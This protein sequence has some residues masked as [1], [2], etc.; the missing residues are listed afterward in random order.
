M[1]EQARKWG[2]DKELLVN[3]IRE[4]E[5]GLTSVIQVSLSF[6][7]VSSQCHVLRIGSLLNWGIAVLKS[8]LHSLLQLHESPVSRFAAFRIECLCPN[9]SGRIPQGTGPMWSFL[10][11]LWVTC[12]SCERWPDLL[13]LASVIPYIFIDNCIP[14]H[15]LMEI[16]FV[17]REVLTTEALI[18]S[19]SNSTASD[20]TVLIWPG[21]NA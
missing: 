17:L 12:S 18:A 15:P 8:F 5:F 4:F 9:C 13:T 19:F 20:V 16:C 10:F 6:Y 14:L 21:F 2:K 1:G 3:R 11:S 7:L